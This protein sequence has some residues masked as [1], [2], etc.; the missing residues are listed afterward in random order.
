MAIHF[1]LFRAVAAFLF[2]YDFPHD[3]TREEFENWGCPKSET[4]EPIDTNF[5]PCDSVCD[6]RM[7]E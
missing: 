5:V 1:F 3:I 4:P 2:V 6:T 7:P